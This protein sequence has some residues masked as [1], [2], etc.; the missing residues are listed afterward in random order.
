MVWQFTER[1]NVLPEKHGGIAVPIILVWA[2]P[3]V[4]RRVKGK[5]QPKKQ[6][7]PWKVLVLEGNLKTVF[8]LDASIAKRGD[9][10]NMANGVA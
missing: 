5:R 8:D 9:A 1:C 6:A 4:F 2:K 3:D 10:H 7:H